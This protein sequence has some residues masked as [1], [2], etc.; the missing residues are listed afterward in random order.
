MYIVQHVWAVFRH[1]MSSFV[2]KSHPAGSVTVFLIT[3]LVH[4]GYYGFS[5]QHILLSGDEPH[6]L[7]VSISLLDDGDIDL[8][9]NYDR[10]DFLRLG[11]QTLGPRVISGDLTHVYPTDPWGFAALLI[12]ALKLGGVFGVKLFL[13]FL[14][15]LLAVSIYHF[16]LCFS[17]C[18]TPSAVSALVVCCSPPVIWYGSQVFPEIAITLFFCTGM[19]LIHRHSELVQKHPFLCGMLPGV[20]PLIHTRGL[21]IAVGMI[22]VMFITFRQRISIRFWYAAPVIL[23]YSIAL[24]GTWYLTDSC[25]PFIPGHDD[26]TSGLQQLRYIPGLLFDRES[27]LFS[28]SP[29][30]LFLALYAV[31]TRCNPGWMLLPIGLHVIV[32]TLNPQ[33]WGGWCPPCRYMIPL[34]PFAAYQISNVV[35]NKAARTPRIVMT[36]LTIVTFVLM[37]PALSDGSIL[38]SRGNGIHSAWSAI[39]GLLGMSFLFPSIRAEEPSADWL[40]I[41]WICLFLLSVCLG[42]DT[43]RKQLKRT[44]IA[45]LLSVI[46][47]MSIRVIPLQIEQFKQW[48]RRLAVPLSTEAPTLLSPLDK[49]DLSDPPHFRWSHVSGTDSYELYLGFPNGSIASCPVPG[50]RNELII[51]PEIWKVVPNGSFKWRVLPLRGSQTGM[52]SA[53]S[54]FHKGHAAAFADRERAVFEQITP[55]SADG[56]TIP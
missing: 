3:F 8:S 18:N 12:P 6:Y 56:L 22:V 54:E 1:T 21:V 27:G 11:L 48:N 33:W 45:L 39:P 24:I 25:Y 32:V 43:R 23:S 31:Y 28:N 15:G 49:I 19:L 53:E 9:N 40:T 52:I 29:L 46:C 41:A 7:M 55:Q 5:A 16:A 42:F 36:I 17:R 38:Y 2:V 35:R 50:G 51:S 14:T 20:L 44:N 30:Y 26:V 37:L 13:I 4:L 10:A 47:M 34:A